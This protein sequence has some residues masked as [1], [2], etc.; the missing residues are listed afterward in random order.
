MII[1]VFAILWIILLIGAICKGERWIIYLIIL[2]YVFQAASIIQWGDRILTP[3]T[4]TCIVYILYKIIRK[5][6]NNSIRLPEELVVLGFFLI[7]VLIS[8]LMA[9][10][11]WDGIEYIPSNESLVLVKY[12]GKVS[13]FSIS[14]LFIQYIC[15][16]LVYNSNMVTAKDLDRVLS[17]SIVIVVIVGIVQ[18]ASLL[19]VLPQDN[20]IIKIVYSS[21]KDIAYNSLIA[22]GTKYYNIL[23]LR[24]HS[25][26]IEPSY[27]GGY[28]AVVLFIFLQKNNNVKN[29]L[30]CLIICVMGILSFSATAY[31]GMTLAFLIKL[32]SSKN[33]WDVSIKR[34]LGYIAI[35]IFILLIAN[36]FQLISIINIRVLNKATTFS[37][38]VREAWNKSA[39]DVFVDTWGL[40]LGHKFRGSSMVYTL[41]GAYGV[42]GIITYMLFFILL[43]IGLWKNKG[44]E[45]RKI[46]YWGLILIMILQFI[47]IGIL[48]Y[49][50]FWMMLLMFCIIKGANYENL[51]VNNCDTTLLRQR[52][53]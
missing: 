45:Y 32:F 18:Y 14:E 48:N 35:L 7:A 5:K 3:S 52:R 20:L 51:S 16:L 33:K 53:K 25:T 28:V 42:I 13:W 39:M 41:L 46:Y 19:Q 50:M 21:N 43:I 47:S 12:E 36:K 9:T 30:K 2:S 27:F 44:S 4:F 37:A 1:S 38:Y 11:L 23:A 34:L 40:G 24:M 29:M 6:D 15:I 22:K 26:F 10:M 17:V 49:C 31:I 8:S